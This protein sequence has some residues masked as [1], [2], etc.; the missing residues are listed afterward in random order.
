VLAEALADLVL[1]VHAGFALFVVAGGLLVRRWRRLIW[2][3]L[4]AA[5]WATAIE[6]GGWIC[7]L[8]P[9]E[10]KLRA[11]T[12]QA[13]YAGDFIQHYMIAVLYPVSLTRPIQIVL[14]TLV[15]TINVIVY[16]VLWR[17]PVS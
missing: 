9:L 17:R 8:T 13:T 5:L 4:P 15:L 7:P 3:H 14:G 10:N 12:G 16:C 1:I 6:L 2:L 11:A